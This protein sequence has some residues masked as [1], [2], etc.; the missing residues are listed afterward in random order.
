[1]S[2][3]SKIGHAFSSAAHAVS[4]AAHTVEHG[5]ESAAKAVGHAAQDV[6]RAV[7]HGAVDAFH[8]IKGGAETAIHGIEHAAVAVE[9]GVEKAAVAVEHGVETAVDETGGFLKKAGKYIGG[10]IK[11]FGKGVWNGVLDIGGGLVG[12]AEDI[13]KGLVEGVGGF[14]SNLVK[15]NVG[16]AFESLIQGADRIVFQAPGRIFNGVLDGANDIVDGASHLLGPLG[17]PIRSVADRAFDIARTAGNTVIELGRDAARLLPETAL[18]FG[19]GLWKTAGDLVH[20]NF[21]QAAKD[22][23]MSF[24]DA[25]A[26]ALGG[27][28]DMVMRTLQGVG[29]IALTAT[30]LQPPS[31]K[32]TDDEKNLLREVY[33]NSVDLDA[34]RISEGGPL[35]NAMAPHTVGNTIYL[36]KN[37]TGQPLFDASGGLTAAGELLVHETGHVW[38][39]QNAGGDYIAQSL[40]NQGVA[41]AQGKSRNEAYDFRSAIADGKSFDQLNPE[42]QAEYIEEV[43]G[44]IL[45]QPGDADANLAASGLTGAD[46]DYAKQ[47]LEDIR[48]GVGAA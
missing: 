22:F 29:S 25:G 6:G 24:V 36:P 16:D 9:H 7:E 41:E 38:Q 39:S 5:V 26:R 20:G 28:G 18:T 35:N 43:L 21:K 13:G 46:L 31:R 27:V 12:A 8:V 34:I 48:N 32:L 47:A 4:D 11:A 30:Y 40:W 33:G 23:G 15:G 3:F 1:M 45:A 42:E 14:F 19:R 44:P 10:E 37:S 2:F 17:K